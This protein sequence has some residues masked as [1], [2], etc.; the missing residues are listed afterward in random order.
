[1]LRFGSFAPQPRSSTRRRMVGLIDWNRAH[2]RRYRQLP[3]VRTRGV[4]QRRYAMTSHLFPPAQCLADREVSRKAK[5]RRAP[6]IH[7]LI[8]DNTHSRAGATLHNEFWY[9]L[10]GYNLRRETSPVR[11]SHHTKGAE[12]TQERTNVVKIGRVR[13]LFGAADRDAIYLVNLR[14]WKN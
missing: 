10:Q 8:M 11:M 3:S 9:A 1:V 5:P 14:H 7:C 6:S 13:R 2:P 12:R 4:L